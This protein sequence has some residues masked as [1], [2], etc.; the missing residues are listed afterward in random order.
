MADR[1]FQTLLLSG[2]PEHPSHTYT[3]LEIVATL[4]QERGVDTYVWNSHD[5]PLPTVNPLYYPNPHINPS[6]AVQR[7]A[8]L[9][10]D[11]DA[12]VWGTPVY[13]N[14][15]SGVLKNALD[16]LN[17]HQFHHKPVAL[18]SSGGSNY[19]GIQ[20]CDQLRIVSRGMQAVAIPTQVVTV[21]SDFKSSQNGY[22]LINDAVYD[23][24]VGIANELLAYAFFMRQL[25]STA[26]QAHTML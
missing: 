18:I 24:L 14:S 2:S 12:F 4:L 10:E 8:R 25:R 20:P 26:F 21:T 9:A 13:H 7:L 23:R 16:N 1:Q 15:F 19:G 17:V 3:S 6:D 5:D 11:A 22:A